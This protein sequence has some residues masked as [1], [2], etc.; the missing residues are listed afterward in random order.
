MWESTII[1]DQGQMGKNKEVL[2]KR[3]FESQRYVWIYSKT[4]SYW[5]YWGIALH[6]I[7]LYQLSTSVALSL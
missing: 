3:L 5:I 7:F 2:I 6:F 4:K 1:I